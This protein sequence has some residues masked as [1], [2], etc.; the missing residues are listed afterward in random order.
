MTDSPIRSISELLSVN[1]YPGRGIVTGK[2]PDGKHAVIAYFIMGRSE[3][4]RNRIFVETENGLR[5]EPFDAS[6]VKD[7][8]LILYTAVHDLKDHLIVSNGDHSDTI[9]EGLKKGLL[10]EAALAVRTFEPDAP[11]YTPR[12]SSVLTFGKRDFTYQ[13]SIL[14]CLDGGGKNAMRNF[15]GFDSVPGLGHF[16]HT[17]ECDGDPLPS[18]SGE[19]RSISVPGSIDEFTGTVWNSLNA[20]NRISL[21]VRYTDLETGRYECRL[22]N[23]NQK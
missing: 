3:N 23:K 20:E 4:S 14:K 21:Y 7:P 19:P 5:T 16:I 10:P 22:I 11:N 18:F 1:A 2:S 6:K 12:I 9:A 15:F 17:Y 13:M 8:S